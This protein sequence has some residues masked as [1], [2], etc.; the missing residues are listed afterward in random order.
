M[1]S[2]LAAVWVI[3]NVFVA[4][5]TAS[6]SSAAS[7][8]SLLPVAPL[9]VAPLPAPHAA[10]QALDAGRLTVPAPA[11]PRLPDT[12]EKLG[13]MDYEVYES[14]PFV[15][16][17]KKLLMETIAL[18]CPE[19]M[20]NWDPR[21]KSCSS[22][23]RIRDLESGTVLRNLTESCNHVSAA[24]FRLLLGEPH[25]SRCAQSFGSAFVD[26]HDDGSETLWVVGSSWV[27]PALQE[28]GAS[29]G[30]L[31]GSRSAEGWGG[32]CSSDATCTVGSFK[33]TDA[34]L[35]SWTVGTV[36]SPGRSSWNVDISTGRPQTDGAKTYVMAI[37][38]HPLPGAPAGS[39]WTSYFYV[40][41][42]PKTDPAFGDLTTGWKLLPTE[43]H[44][45]G[46]PGTHGACPTIRFIPDSDGGMYYV[47]SGGLSVYL[48]RS[49]NLS[50]WEPSSQH[51][52]VLQTSIND[53][54]VCTEY[55]GCKC[56]RSLCVFV[57]KVHPGS[58]CTDKPRPSEQALLATAKAAFAKGSG[59]AWDCDASDVD[60]WEMGDGTTLFYFLS[61]NQ[62]NH[63]FAA[64]GCARPLTDDAYRWAVSS[65][66]FLRVLQAV[67]RH[68]GRVVRRAV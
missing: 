3:T 20:G 8:P 63:I 42:E 33:T 27:R 9:P 4:A 55:I 49:R 52:V 61:G 18:V 41:D 67:Q 36:L 62:G 56:S 1:T 21:Y 15:F 24:A 40:K 50:G 30:G 46:G 68:D 29:S 47:I 31:V 16:R 7:D 51:G 32:L 60:L 10:A 25:G 59:C 22:Y 39:G 28:L 58:C 45:I 19:H 64:L 53:T 57:R 26:A 13:M 43:T 38:Q 14:T 48:D 65:H 44:V 12:F 2:A 35:Q 5:A 34:S 23:Y 11:P 54:K 17:K 37:E 6:S 66:R